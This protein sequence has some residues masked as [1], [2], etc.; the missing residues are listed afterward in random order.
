M[1]EL[2]PYNSCLQR[3][4][5]IIDNQLHLTEKSTLLKKT[6]RFSDKRCKPLKT[7]KN[8]YA[9]I[10]TVRVS[11]TICCHKDR[12]EDTKGVAKLLEVHT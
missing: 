4:L 11:N 10:N 6:F 5:E 3:I 9:S 1:I 8:N 12:F 2:K 7:I